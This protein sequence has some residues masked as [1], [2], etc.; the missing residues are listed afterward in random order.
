MKQVYER[1]KPIP[2]AKRCEREKVKVSEN[3]RP[4]KKK[5]ICGRCSGYLTLG[6][7]GFQCGSGWKIMAIIVPRI[8]K[9]EIGVI[10]ITM[11]VKNSYDT[12]GNSQF[13]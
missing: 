3:H 9:G 11:E 12:I 6:L 7:A 1:T 10:P 8:P 5:I 13:T 4:L 2:Q